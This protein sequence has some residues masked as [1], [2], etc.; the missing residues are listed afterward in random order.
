MIILPSKPDLVVQIVARR[1]E[2]WEAV[3]EVRERWQITDPPAELPP[4]SE[5]VLLPPGVGEPNHSRAG[6]TAYLNAKRRWLG[7]LRRVLLRGGVSESYVEDQDAH[8]TGNPPV[9]SRLLPAYRF[10][11]AC[12]LFDPPHSERLPDFAEYGG[13]QRSSDQHGAARL[14]TE[15]ELG[16]RALPGEEQRA[17]EEM[18]GQKMWELRSELGGLE[19][20]QARLEVLRRFHAQMRRELERLR[21][22]RE[23]EIEEGS[24]EG[25]Y[26]ELAEGATV[27][28][29]RRT[30]EEAAAHLEGRPTVGRR[31]RDPLIAT[32]C[33]VLKDECGWSYRQI[34]D[35]FDWID[36]TAVSKY[37][38]DGRRI[39]QRTG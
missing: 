25:V 32:T 14:L 16:L 15:Q 4:E 27:K 6:Y 3:S 5:D 13:P 7:D 9:P 21:E 34:A 26:V 8:H 29:M 18:V 37:L 24:P 20:R 28:E 10:A 30:V 39:L 22:D 1:G 33:A 35:H 36:E 12:V 2:F 11:A 17:L 19:Y 23:Q 31:R 38:K